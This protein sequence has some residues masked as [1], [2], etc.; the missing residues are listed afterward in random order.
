MKKIK[1]A[2][3]LIVFGKGSLSEELQDAYDV[4]VWRNPDD[5]THTNYISAVWAPYERLG[6]SAFMP[7]KDYHPATKKYVD[8]VAAGS[9]H[10][11]AITPNTNWTTYTVSQEWVGTQ[12][13]YNA[14]TP[15]NWVIYNIIPS[16]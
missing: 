14:I 6:Y 9:V 3:K 7:T 4:R 5:L 13:Q 10:V 8:A 15:V 16:S 1:N 11:P 12:A 2:D